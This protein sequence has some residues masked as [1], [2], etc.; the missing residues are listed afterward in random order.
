MRLL[1]VSFVV[2]IAILFISCDEVEN[3]VNDTRD[4]KIT[5]K[6]KL[7]EVMN[8]AQTDF[9]SDAM[10]AAI[11]GREVDTNGEIDLLNTSSFNAFVYTMQSDVLQRNEFYV[12][13]FGAGPVKSPINFNTM[14][15]FVKDST[16]KN[17]MSTLFGRLATIAIDPNANY[18]DSPEVLDILFMRIDVNTFRTVNPNS[19]IDMFLVPSKSIDSTSVVNSADWIVNFY[20]DSTS[21]V[22]WINSSS[23]EIKNLGEI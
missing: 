18:N 3:L 10:L 14:L 2:G 22:L 5:A 17:V 13:V 7:D 15:S 6:E 16:A 23:G 19:K 20:G 21:L 12:P 11:Y 4:G 1:F 8:A 9:S